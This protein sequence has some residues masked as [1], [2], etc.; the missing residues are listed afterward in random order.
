VVSNFDTHQILF[1]STDR[2]RWSTSLARSISPDGSLNV[3]GWFN[4]IFQVRPRYFI[5]QRSWFLSV[6]FYLFKTERSL[7]RKLVESLQRGRATFRCAQKNRKTENRRG[8]QHLIH[9]K[10][11]IK[12]RKRYTSEPSGLKRDIAPSLVHSAPSLRLQTCTTIPGRG[13]SSKLDKLASDKGWCSLRLLVF[14]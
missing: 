1:I 13:N 8:R 10:A 2:F 11:W 6:D 12:R 5:Q 14:N 3:R 7:S 4:A 9:L